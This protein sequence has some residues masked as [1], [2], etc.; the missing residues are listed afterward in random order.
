MEFTVAEMEAVK[1]FNSEIKGDDYFSKDLAVKY[2]NLFA[3]EGFDPLTT[4]AIIKK[5]SQSK[6]RDMK[7]DIAMMISL[8]LERGSNIGRLT[9]LTNCRMSREGH[10]VVLD[11]ASTY[12]IVSGGKQGRLAIT[13]PRVA[14]SVP[15]LT[16][17]YAKYYRMNRPYDS[18]VPKCME[19]SAF[20]SLIP[21]VKPEAMD[22]D[23]YNYIYHCHAH[24]MR[25]LTR[26]LNRGKKDDD[27]VR[28]ETGQYIA[29][30]MAGPIYPDA[31]RIEKLVE[32][33]IISQNWLLTGKLG[34]CFLLE[35]PT[36]S[37]L[38]EKKVKKKGHKE[39]VTLESAQGS[40]VSS[41]ESA[42]TVISRKE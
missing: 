9:S 27:E 1:T 21:R 26:L 15:F 39:D 6:R 41:P 29:A 7:E 10:K 5:V 24:A 34:E 32:L 14:A 28:R 13:L 36:K 33:K 42:K 17:Y 37:K 11:L 25:G 30:A 23:V 4:L 2:A 40:D 38:V 8:F 3:Y 16:C 18:G 35:H 31:E 19:V 12:N 22:D 20:G